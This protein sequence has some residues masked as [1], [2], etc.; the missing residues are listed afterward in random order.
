MHSAAVDAVCHQDNGEGTLSQSCCSA[1]FTVVIQGARHAFTQLPLPLRLF[2][3]NKIKTD[4]E[5]K[6]IN[7]SSHSHF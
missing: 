1:A 4:F 2:C 5:G 3:F 7:S 6:K